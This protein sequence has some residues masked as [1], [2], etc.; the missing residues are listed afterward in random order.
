MKHGLKIFYFLLALISLVQSSSAGNSRYTEPYPTAESK[1]GLQVELVDDALHLGIKHA[2]L[3]I[4]LSQL[5]DPS[6]DPKNPAWRYKGKSYHFQRG[7]L[8]RMDS[9]IHALSEKGV[10]VNLIVLAYQSHD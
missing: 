2:G 10:L 9:Q 8:A 4:N 1:K 3:N 6:A 7:Y 5:I